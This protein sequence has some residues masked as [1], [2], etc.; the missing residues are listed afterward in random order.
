[1]RADRQR[2]MSVCRNVVWYEEVLEVSTG[3]RA[4]SSASICSCNCNTYI[5]YIHVRRCHY[6]YRYP[7]S[8]R[9]CNV[10]R[11]SLWLGGGGFSTCFR[12]ASDVGCQRRWVSTMYTTLLR[13]LLRSLKL[14]VVLD[15]VAAGDTIWPCVLFT[16]LSTFSFPGLLV[17]RSFSSPILSSQVMTSV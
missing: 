14:F 11:D 10:R 16:A 12:R 15:L 17:S 5:L 2:T 3:C 8:R 1:M 13:V 9:H 7:I 4:D 6:Y